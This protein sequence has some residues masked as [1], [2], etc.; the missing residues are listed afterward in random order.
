MSAK[1]E[2][3]DTRM[4]VWDIGVNYLIKGHSSKLTLDYQHRPIY[5]PNGNDFHHIGSRGQ[6]VLQYQVFF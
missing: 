1:Y 5:E 6:V 3:L 4:V 2:R